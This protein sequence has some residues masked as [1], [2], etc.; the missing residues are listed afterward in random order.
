VSKVLEIGI[1]VGRHG[2]YIYGVG[3]VMLIQLHHLGCYSARKQFA[4]HHQI[5]LIRLLNA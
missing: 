5:S 3:G 1:K 2:E 4:Y